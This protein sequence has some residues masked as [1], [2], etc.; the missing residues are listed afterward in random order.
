MSTTGKKTKT[1]PAEF[2]TQSSTFEPHVGEA[3]IPLEG[4]EVF[5]DLLKKLSKANWFCDVEEA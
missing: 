1:D 3:T 2:D 4:L 5:A